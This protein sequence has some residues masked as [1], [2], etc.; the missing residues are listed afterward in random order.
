MISPFRK[1]ASVRLLHHMYDFARRSARIAADSLF[2]SASRPARS[3]KPMKYSCGC[4]GVSRPLRTTPSSLGSIAD[5]T[6]RLMGMGKRMK[7]GIGNEMGIGIEARM[8]R[9]ALDGKGLRGQVLRRAQYGCRG[10]HAPM[11]PRARVCDRVAIPT[12]NQG[13]S[14]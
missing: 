2:I 13:G 5:C 9:G 3:L 8:M 4:S 7:M 6:P 12:S 14:E 1:N 10:A 11:P